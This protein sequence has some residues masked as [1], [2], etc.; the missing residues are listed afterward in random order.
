MKT[1]VSIASTVAALLLLVR[2]VAAFRPPPLSA[3]EQKLLRENFALCKAKLKGPYTENFCVCPGGA[4]L[5][6]MGPDGR[7]RTPCKDALF[8][9]AFR[10]P[11]AEALA[12]ERMYIANIFSRD[13]YLWGSFPDH[14]DLVRGYILEKYFTETNPHHKLSQLKA[15]GGLSGAEYET[16]ASAHFFERYLSSPE[17]SDYRDF[18]LAYELQRRYF[19]RADLGQIDKVRALSVRIYQADPKFKPLRDAVHNQLS[20]GLVPQLVA[21][22]DP[23]PAGPTR[24]QVDELIAEIR[25]L[26]SLGES[27]LAAQVGEIQD[28]AL[29]SQLS[30]SIP[31][32]Q[33][34]PVDAISSLA[35]LMVFCRR[36]VAAHKASAADSRRLVDLDIT[37]AG[38]IQQRGSALLDSSPS[39]TVGQHLRLLSALTDATYATGLL[40][41]R[42]HEAA[43]AALRALMAGTQTSRADFTEKL[44]AGG[45]RRRVGAG[46]RRSC[47]CRGLGAVDLPA[48]ASR[49]HPRRYPAQLSVAALRSGLASAR[50]LRRGNAAL[51]P[52]PLRHRVRHR[53][54]CPQLRARPRTPPCRAEG[55]R[56]RARRDCRAPRDSGR[57]RTRRRHPHAGRRQ[58]AVARPAAGARSR[59]SQRGARL[60][61][62]SGRSRR[63]TGARSSSSSPR[64]AA[65]SSRKPRP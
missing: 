47:L 20:P 31:A 32:P 10:A 44:E 23:L 51:P 45:A 60:R 18:L 4:K 54:P 52:R 13:L 57:S 3:Q 8:C 37:A 19:V 43:V 21:F 56:L 48:A 5:P 24:S 29:R 6:V 25:K 50:R 27:A 38:V 34:D 16:L 64:G 49:R 42:E 17:F 28:A 11:W 55:R 59:N 15:Y 33:A 62:L 40:G 2:P 63:T 12:K 39:L 30:A 36:T 26:T 1:Y 7:I 46:Q 14:N 9:A 61:C 65:S 35:Q 41:E 58:R 53:R 22:R